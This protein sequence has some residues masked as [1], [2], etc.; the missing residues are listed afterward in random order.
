[1]VETHDVLFARLR[2]VLVETLRFPAGD[3]APEAA[4]L[5]LGLDSLDA[6]ELSSALLKRW[7]LRVAVRDVFATE[8]LRDIVVLMERSRVPAR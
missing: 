5:D 6:A 2:S 7:G 3:V 4:V 8:T 1:M